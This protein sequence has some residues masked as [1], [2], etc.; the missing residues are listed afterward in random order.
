[1]IETPAAYEEQA[2]DLAVLLFGESG[3]DTQGAVPPQKGERE[4]EPSSFM[5]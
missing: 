1:V 2:R 5:V 3:S 4:R